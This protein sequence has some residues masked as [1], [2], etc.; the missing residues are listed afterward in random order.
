[1]RAKWYIFSSYI[2]VM[3]KLVS[4]VLVDIFCTLSMSLNV[5]P[6]PWTF[7]KSKL[8]L[9]SH[10]QNKQAIFNM[11]TNAFNFNGSLGFVDTGVVDV[12]M[13]LK[14]SLAVLRRNLY[15]SC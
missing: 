6:M 12:D 7:D 13:D 14:N 9:N 5:G 8:E 2:N 4:G 11:H 3:N 1:M 15:R 10:N